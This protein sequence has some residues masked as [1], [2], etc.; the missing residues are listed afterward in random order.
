MGNAKSAEPCNKTQGFQDYISKKRSVSLTFKKDQ[1]AT[2]ANGFIL[3]TIPKPSEGNM[4]HL[5][6]FSSVC[7]MVLSFFTLST[8]QILVD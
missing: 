1:I 4:N 8:V 3:G 2:A 5:A 7:M 6:N